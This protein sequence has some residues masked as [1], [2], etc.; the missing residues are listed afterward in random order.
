[1]A[2]FKEVPRKRKRGQPDNKQEEDS[3]EPPHSQRVSESD[4]WHDLVQRLSSSSSKDPGVSEDDPDHFKSFFRVS[5]KTFDYICNLVRQDLVSRP[6]SGLINIEGRLLT[7]EKQVAIALRRLASGDP[8]VSVG[9]Q[10]G[11][12]QSTVS[13]VTWRFVESME[14]RGRHHLKWPDVQEMEKVKAGFEQH[15]LPNCCGAVDV[16]HIIMTLPSVESSTDWYDREHNYS[17]VLQAIVDMDMRFR[18]ILT[19]WPGS[20][21]DSQLLRNSGFFRL[22][23]NGQRLHGPFRRLSQGREIRE[24]IVGDLGYPLLSW[25]L[26][27]FQDKDLNDVSR[28]YNKKHASTASIAERALARLKGTWRILHRV[29]WRPDKHKLPRI[30]LVCC[31]LHNIII[32]RGDELLSGVALPD[33][34]DKGYKQQI[35]QYADPQGKAGRDTLAEFLHE[36]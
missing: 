30:I 33:H 18:D 2:P 34:H 22:C 10:F 1:M 15:G 16:T 6:P 27:P 11:V 4:W 32:D 3:Q 28:S 7:V 31:L 14:E 23:E 29:M 17:M 8:Q 12:G 21:N 25:L 9:E 24:F 36:Q 13:Q 35:C 26:T 20:M 19:G 5:R